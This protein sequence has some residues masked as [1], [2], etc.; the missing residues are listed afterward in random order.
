MTILP[1]KK[2]TKDKSESENTEHSAGHPHTLPH[3]H[4]PHSHNIQHTHALSHPHVHGHYHHPTPAESRLEK[5]PTRWGPTLASTSREEKL[6]S[7]APNPAFEFDYESHESPTNHKRRHRSS[8][9]RTARKHRG[10]HTGSAQ[11]SPGT[12]N[13]YDVEEEEDGFNSEDEHVQPPSGPGSG[14]ENKEVVDLSCF[15]T[16]VTR[17]INNLVRDMQKKSS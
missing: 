10:A 1:K 4:P 17:E 6:H 13:A 3:G 16:C 9:H 7:V 14:P 2:A 12:S 8:P 5:A 11:N 15:P